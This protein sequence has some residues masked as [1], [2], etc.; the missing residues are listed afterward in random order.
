MVGMS[1]DER[2]GESPFA[3]SAVQGE[4]ESL[5]FRFGEQKVTM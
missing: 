4:H 2:E 3:G 5:S 1:E